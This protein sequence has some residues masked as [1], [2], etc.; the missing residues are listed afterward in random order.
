MPET[1]LT[2]DGYNASLHVE[3]GHL[4]VR[5]G[6]TQAERREVRFPRGRCKVNR[7]V[8]RAPGGT[9][10]MDAIRWCADM[11][12]A[13]SFVDSDS[14]LLNC[15]VPDASHDG[16][17]KRAQAV[18]AV[19]DDALHL[20][21]YLL[22]KKMDSQIHAMERD[23]PRL[24]IGTVSGNSASTAQV[25]GCKA[26]LSK[27][28]TLVD[29]L[30][31]EGRAAQFY[32]DVLVET[33]LPW[34]PW[35]LSRIPAHWAAISSRTS[36]RRDRVRDATDPFNAVLNYAYTLLEVETRIACEA[37]GLDPDLGLIHIDDRL[38]ESFIYDVLE[39]LRANADVWALELLRKQTMRPEMFHELRDGVVRLDPDLAGLLAKSL[40]PRFRSAALDLAN[41]YARQLRRVTISRRLVRATVRP[42]GQRR[43]DWERSSCGYCKGPLPR[44]GLKYCGRD[45]YVR[46]S[47]EIAKPIEKA[48]KRLAEMRASGLNPG[49][50]GAAA[51]K[52]G[53]AL[54]ENN[55]KGI[56]GRRTRAV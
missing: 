22:A 11:G 26:A 23:F 5:D 18:S 19:T 48:Q 6:F 34:R 47:V 3:R 13:L 45:C 49:H 32:W 41:D 17:V 2:V 15:M 33:P 29:F 55:R 27:A 38:R 53:A 1:I 42:V 14:R 21:R 10:T 54:A 43:N 9:I 50:G 37:T 35:A 44:K 40:M 24:G 51:R 25:H 28:T 39:P 20:A 16:P 56:T 4:V 12:V 31:L 46:Y 7:I 8:V 36:G 30:G 52:R